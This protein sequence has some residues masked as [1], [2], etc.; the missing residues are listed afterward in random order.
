MKRKL[1]SS[2][3]QYGLKFAVRTTI[4]IE[5]II[6]SVMMPCSEHIVASVHPKK[7]LWERGSKTKLLPK[8]LNHLENLPVGEKVDQQIRMCSSVTNGRSRS[9]LWTEDSIGKH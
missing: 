1:N 2:E 4:T 7:V 3:D 5:M 6:K 8:Q 9:A